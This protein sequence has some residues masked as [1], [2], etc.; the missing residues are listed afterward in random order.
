MQQYTAVHMIV[1]YNKQYS[2]MIFNSQRACAVRIMV[3]GLY[4]V[5]LSVSYHA[6]CHHAHE[7]TK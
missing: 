4:Y 7:T 1:F 2:H 6:F 3:L 5:C